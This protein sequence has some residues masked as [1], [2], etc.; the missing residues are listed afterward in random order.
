MTPLNNIAL[1]LFLILSTG[2]GLKPS[3]DK[4]EKYS[5]S[6]ACMGTTFRIVTYSPYSYRDTATIIEQAYVL[7]EEMNNVFSDYMADSEVGKFNRSEPNGPQAASPY[8]LDLLKIS[9]KISVSTKGGFDPTCGSLSKLWRLSK[10]TNKLPSSEKLRTTKNACGFS[11]LKIDHKSAHI[12][13]LNPLTRLDFGGI[14]KG[15][16]ADKMLQL[17]KNKGLPSSSIAAGG[18][19]VTGESPPG[20]D[21]WEVQIIP[22]RDKGVKPITIRVTNAAVSTSGNTEQTIKIKNQR[23]SHI[24]DPTSG[25]GLI[26]NNAATVIAPS[27]AQS[28]SLA[29]ALCIGGKDTLT[30]INKSPQF[31]AM[32]FNK[33][34]KLIEKIFSAG[35]NKFVD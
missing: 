17:L 35:F 20:K 10:R 1:T 33:R 28:D 9:R 18:D 7:A 32:L 22:Y 3:E 16:T 6:K 19:I 25:L 29:T 13:K 23:Y 34:D 31:E 4:I 11:N 2:T 12:T 5:F 14:A 30:I 24:L 21:S 8:L 26:H 15:Y 27:G